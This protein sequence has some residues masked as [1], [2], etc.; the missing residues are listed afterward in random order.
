MP[1]AHPPWWT[2][3]RKAFKLAIM[4]PADR[5]SRSHTKGTRPLQF[6]RT[7]VWVL[8]LSGLLIFSY[9]NWKVVEI[10][11]W[12]EIVVE[13]KVPALVIVAFLLGLVPTWLYHRSVRWGLKRR[14]RSLENSIKSSALSQ[15]AEPA[16][17]SAA[18]EGR[19]G[20]RSPGYKPV[21]NP[22][23]KLAEPRES[24]ARVRGVAA[25]PAAKDA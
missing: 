2:V 18:P 11:L 22:E 1:S 4:Q 24:M 25:D 14:I 17:P 7:I 21:E 6:V 8:I 16:V 10:A 19:K 13:A 5:F 15:P 20:G 23:N 12:D 9:L 3:P